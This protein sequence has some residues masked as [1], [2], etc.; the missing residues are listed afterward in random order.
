MQN[1]LIKHGTY[2]MLN[3]ALVFAISDASIQP[4]DYTNLI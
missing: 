1:T 3:I 2:R 4:A